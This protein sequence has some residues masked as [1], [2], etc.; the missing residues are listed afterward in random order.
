MLE[1]TA[2]YCPDRDPYLA[3]DHKLAAVERMASPFPEP[4]TG[5]K[6]TPTINGERIES[7][8]VQ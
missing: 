2:A 8:L 1:E 3:P 6:L 5:T 4:R 7:R